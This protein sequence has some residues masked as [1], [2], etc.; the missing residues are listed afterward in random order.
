VHALVT[1]A[2]GFVG[3]HLALRLCYEGHTVT[4]ID[5]FTD[6]YDV[7]LKRARAEKVVASGA[8]LIEADLNDV[9]I[10][11]LLDGVDVVFHQAGQPGVRAS[12]GS[13]FST[14]I[15]CNIAATQRLLEASRGKKGLRRFVYA[16]SSSVY[17]DAEHYPTSEKDR[18]QPIS[19]YGVT[20]LAAEHLCS[21]YASNFGVPTVSLRYFTVYGPG[22]RPDMAFTRFTKAAVH[23]GEIV[24]FGTGDQIRDFT[25]VDDVVEANILAATH[26]VTPGK[27]FNVAGGSHSSV[28]EVLAILEELAGQKLSVRREEAVAG[29]VKR[30]GGDTSAIRSSLGWQPRI[31]LREGLARHLD[32]ARAQ[33]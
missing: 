30:T 23:G 8:E 26:E 13:E 28:N 4:G 19:P 14:Y 6:Y 31:G 9:D 18:P 5:S 17:G 1:G 32:W 3:S 25:Y 20:K 2:A 33:S 12:W 27:V 15:H 11:T 16:S 7:E 24:V 22:Q 21:L 10:N 29:D